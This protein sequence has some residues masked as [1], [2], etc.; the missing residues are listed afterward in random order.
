MS[1]TDDA[2]ACILQ[3][4]FQM[5]RFES[6]Y[7]DTRLQPFLDARKH[8]PGTGTRRCAQVS[9]ASEERQRNV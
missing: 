8:S 7:A 5:G 6:P 2:V 9:G 4:K 3:A 1:R